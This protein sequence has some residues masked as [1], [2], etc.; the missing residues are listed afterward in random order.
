[1]SAKAERGGRVRRFRA[2]LVK[3]SIQ[4][5]RDPSSILIAFV[6]PL[7]LLFVYGYGVS[8]DA[9]VVRIGVAVEVTNEAS[10][11]LVAAFRASRFFDVTA[12]RDRREL[13]PLLIAGGIRGIVVIP[14]SF[15]EA[16]ARNLARAQIQVQTDGSETNTAKFVENYAQGV[17]ANWAASRSGN[18]APVQAVSLVPRFWYNPELRSRYFLV[19]GC[20]AM[21]MTLVG[22]LLTALVVAREWERGTM[23]AMMATPISTA[24][25][26][27]GQADPLFRAWPRCYGTVHRRRCLSVRRAAQRFVARAVVDF[28]RLPDAGARPRTADLLGDQEPV[29]RLAG[30]AAIGLHAG[31]SAVRL[32]LRDLEHA[33]DHSDRHLYRPGPLPHPEPANGFPCGRYLAALP[34]KHRRHAWY[35]RGLPVLDR[36]QHKKESRMMWRRLWALIV[37]ELRA[38]LRDPRGRAILI[39][40]PLVQMFLFSYAATLDVSNIDIGV[41]NRDAGRWSVEFL[42]QLRG[43]PAFRRITR[44]AD[45][46]EAQDA[47]DN[48]RVIATL[49]FGPDFSRDIEAGRPAEVQIVLDGRRSNASQIVLGYISAIASGIA[50][51]VQVKT[52]FAGSGGSGGAAHRGAPL[53]QRQSRLY[54]VYRARASSERLACSSR[55]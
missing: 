14:A 7:I 38:V 20:I 42:H 29:R 49:H 24:E 16:A 35:R 8:L 1:M 9:N 55:W 17:Y 39:G 53:V 13:E 19:P 12:A 33:E 27:S 36:A 10:Q 43:A 46:H 45:Q 22:T 5:L 54:L 28:L 15:G 31:L 6:L 18:G 25:T 21:V 2:L 26:H 40:P 47:I 34:A 23:E 11:S 51:P 3:E 32:H 30:G 50:T 4:I 48:R 37:K 52:A 44:F 41:L